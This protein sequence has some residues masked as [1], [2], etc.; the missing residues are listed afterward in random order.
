FDNGVRG[1]LDICMF[2][3]ATHNQEE[4]SVVGDLGKIEALIPENIL[5]TGRR[6]T[7]SIGEVHVTEVPTTSVGY[8]GLHHGSSYR[9]HV[10]FR[11]A[12][13]SDGESEVTLEDG[14]MSVA[15]GVAA[16]LSIDEA[17]PVEMTELL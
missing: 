6:G 9:E 15:V 8:E 4:L 7:H 14:L 2:A 3:E 16:Q 13:Q 12:V 10:S 5:R 17:R 11:D 1:M